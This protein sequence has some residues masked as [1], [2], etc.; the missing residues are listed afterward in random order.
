L[1][2]KFNYMFEIF[3]RQKIFIRERRINLIENWFRHDIVEVF[4][5]PK[6]SSLMHFLPKKASN[7]IQT[8]IEI[9]EMRSSINKRKVFFFK[10]L[11]AFCNLQ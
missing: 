11:K 3:K 2:F 5:D 6:F 9:L 8:E 1:D 10:I 4:K 7:K